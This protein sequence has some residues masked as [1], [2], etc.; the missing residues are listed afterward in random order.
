MT[1]INCVPVAELTRAHL[2]S[3]YREIT[4]ARSWQIHERPLP[5]TYRMG[6]G[7]CLFFHDKGLWLQTRHRALIAEMQRRGYNPTLPPLDLGHWP[8]WAMGDWKPDAEAMAVNRARIS[9]RLEGK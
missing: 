1:R 6:K 5:P 9:E 4:R 2:V 3:E 8:P 7:H